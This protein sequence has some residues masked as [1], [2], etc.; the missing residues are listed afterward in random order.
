[1][2]DIAVIVIIVVVATLLALVVVGF[3]MKGRSNKA[4]QEPVE[5]P[6]PSQA[7]KVAAPRPSA[8]PPTPVVPAREVLA[9]TPAPS[10]RPPVAEAEAETDETDE[11]DDWGSDIALSEELDGPVEGVPGA[12]T[13]DR[14]SVV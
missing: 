4:S 8:R 13:A 14:K 1:M 9:D 6:L 10:P 12:V 7:R 5:A 2:N 11:A 3:L